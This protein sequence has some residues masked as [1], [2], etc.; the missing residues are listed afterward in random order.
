MINKFKTEDGV[1]Q[2][3]VDQLDG[4]CGIGVIHDVT[5]I[6]K[7][8]TQRFFKAFNA[9]LHRPVPKVKR[10]GWDY[11]YDNE[12]DRE[13]ISMGENGFNELGYRM[14][15]MTDRLNNP[16]TESISK[17]CK[18]MKWE[19]ISKSKSRMYGNYMLGMWKSNRKDSV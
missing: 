15:L 8:N 12:D 13:A 6:I 5:F 17:F 16:Y 3:Y 18:T 2:Y 14:L 10:V 7:G 1:V 11:V 4:C 19:L 9:H